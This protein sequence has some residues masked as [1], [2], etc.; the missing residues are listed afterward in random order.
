MGQ[1][2]YRRVIRRLVAPPALPAVIRPRAPDGPEHVAAENPRADTGEAV[3]RHSLSIPVSPSV[4]S[5]HP[6]P[7]AR[8]EEPLH[9]LGA[10]D[11]ERVLEILIRPG[12]VAV[13]GDREALDAEFR[14]LLN[15]LVR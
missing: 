11:A 9:Q 12:A 7:H 14:H 15:S 3:L 13:D 8:G 6:A 2:E 10:V 4:L 1:Y 5:V